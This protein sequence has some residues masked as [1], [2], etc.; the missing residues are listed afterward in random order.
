MNQQ[1]LTESS[2]M[3]ELDCLLDTRIGVIASMGGDELK[4]IIATDYHNRAMDIFPGIDNDKFQE[5]YANRDKTILKN[6]MITPMGDMLKDFVHKT[7]NLIHTSPFHMKPKIII[8]L[9]PYQLNED[10]IVNII[11]SVRA[12]TLGLADVTAVN[13]SYEQ[14]TP[15]YVK[16]NV[17]I[18][19][20]YEYYKWLEAQSLNEA[21]K[22]VTCPE[23]ALLGPAIFFKIPD[24]QLK[25]DDNPFKAMEELAAPFI[26]L[27]LI[28]IKNFSL[29]TQFTKD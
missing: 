29:V 24:K 22:K 3:I 11:V 15:S 7:I 21:F 16:N 23:V 18:L 27:G 26:S 9:Y 25:Q 6:S 4:T 8:N 2:L 5:M 14:L 20:L 1:E 10:E 12:K 19:V 13:L 28:P 17:S